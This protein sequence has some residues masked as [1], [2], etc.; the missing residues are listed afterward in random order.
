MENFPHLTKSNILFSNYKTFTF[1]TVSMF[2]CKTCSSLFLPQDGN[3]HRLVVQSYFRLTKL[4][5]M[6]KLKGTGRDIRV[7][8]LATIL[9]VS[10]S[11]ITLIS[12]L[13]DLKHA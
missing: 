13:A 11:Y 7:L 8:P 3:I 2:A 4:Q 1:Q 9:E 10:H 5:R 12:F 6:T